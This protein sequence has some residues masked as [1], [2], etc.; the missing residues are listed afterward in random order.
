MFQ[1]ST[2]KPLMQGVLEMGVCVWM[3]MGHSFVM[4]WL[5]FIRNDYYS[6]ELWESEP[7]RAVAMGCTDFITWQH[8]VYHCLMS[9]LHCV[10][11]CNVQIVLLD[12]ANCYGTQRVH[13]NVIQRLYY[14]IIQRLHCC[15][16][17]RVHQFIID[18]IVTLWCRD[19]MFWLSVMCTTMQCTEYISW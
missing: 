2:T 15:A 14:N 18:K 7:K 5:N 6:G 10:S 8:R 1:Q 19:W 13:H 4:L 9:R 3:T 11:P 12:N 16:M 17:D